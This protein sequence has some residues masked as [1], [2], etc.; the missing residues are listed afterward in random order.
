[1]LYKDTVCSS[2]EQSAATR[3]TIRWRLYRTAMGV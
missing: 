1:M 2:Q 3:A